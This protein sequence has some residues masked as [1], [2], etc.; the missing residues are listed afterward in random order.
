MPWYSKV[1]LKFPQSVSCLGSGA[2]SVQEGPKETKKVTFAKNL[3]IKEPK[4]R[5]SPYTP[6]KR[7]INEDQKALKKEKRQKKDTLS[8]K[9]LF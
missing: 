2:S 8:S 6:K 1:G 9:D 7:R 4:K 5:L 3:K